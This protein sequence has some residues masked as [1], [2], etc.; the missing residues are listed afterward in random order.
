MDKNKLQCN[1]LQQ[2]MLEQGYFIKI[3]YHIIFALHSNLVQLRRTDCVTVVK[4]KNVTQNV[5]GS[6]ICVVSSGISR[7]KGSIDES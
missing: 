7:K 3:S 4:N 1:S 6:N 2:M 5:L